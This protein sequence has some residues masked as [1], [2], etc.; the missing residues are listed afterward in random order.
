MPSNLGAAIYGLITVGA[1]L[2]AETAQSETYA[3]TVVAVVI[4]LLI[5]WLAHS[6]ADLTSWRLEASE[7]LRLKSLMQTMM[8]SCRSCSVRR[9]RCW[10]W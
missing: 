1:L 2:A 6:Y 8:A 5:Y 3:E 4:T 9:F 7:S 10:R